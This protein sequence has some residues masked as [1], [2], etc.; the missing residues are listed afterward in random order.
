M[1]EEWVAVSLFAILGA[2]LIF[3]EFSRRKVELAA[4]EKGLAVPAK[5]KTDARKPALV[6]IAL[7]VGFSVC[8]FTTLS[9]I[10]RSSYDP[11]PLAISVWGLV[12]V[13]VGLAL[14]QYHKI[15]QREEA[16]KDAGQA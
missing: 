11:S 9:S 16:E 10:E 8:M 4:I 2:Y 1:S 5:Q 7:G 14:W 15:Q 12:P 6:L 3:K 13:L